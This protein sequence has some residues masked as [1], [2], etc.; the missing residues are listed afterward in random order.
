[1]TFTVEGRVEIRGQA[2]AA[3]QLRALSGE[4]QKLVDHTTGVSTRNK[5]AS[6][7]AAVFSAALTEQEEALRVLSDQL[8]PVTRKSEEFLAVQ[9]QLDQAVG[10]GL[11][12]RGDADKM[13]RAAEKS[14]GGIATAADDMGVRVGNSSHQFKNIAYQLNQI[15]QMGAVTK[16]W[17]GA[18]AIQI[19]DI[20]ASFGGLGM[21]LAGGA[22]AVGMSLVPAMLNAGAAAGDLTDMIDALQTSVSELN[23]AIDSAHGSLSEMTDRFGDNV[24]QARE[25]LAIQRQLAEL[26]AFA[27]FDDAMVGIDREF[28]VARRGAEEA[29]TALQEYRRLQA[30][31]SAALDE[32][33]R[34]G[35]EGIMNDARMT[36]ANNRLMTIR[37]QIDA[38]GDVEAQL[39]E[40]GS[41]FGVSA[42]Q[43]EQLVRA[44]E[45][46]GDAQGIADQTVA[47]Q[48]LLAM[49]RDFTKGGFGGTTEA[50]EM[51]RLL[52]DAVESGLELASLDLA[53]FDEDGAAQTAAQA[54]AVREMVDQYREQAQIAQAVNAFGQESLQVLLLRRE[55]HAA[56]VE[57]MIA[58]AGYAEEAA[59]AIREAAMAAYDAEEGILAGEVAAAA[60]GRTLGLLSFDA[61]I[62][63]ADTLQSKLSGMMGQA[64]SLLS[65]MGRAGQAQITADQQRDLLKTERDM[66]AAG[67]SRVEIEGALAEQRTRF[68]H[69]Q[70][71]GVKLFGIGDAVLDV[72]AGQARRT[73][74]ETATLN[75][76][77][78][79]LNR[80]QTEAAGSG[81]R[82]ADVTQK[83]RDAVADLIEALRAEIDLLG[84]SDPVQ[85]E[86]IK[87]RETL[88][89]ATDAERQEVQKLIEQRRDEEA[90]MSRLEYVSN[91]TGNALIQALM[92]AEDAGDRLIDTLLEA[93]L[94]AAILGDGPL[95]GLFG[96]G[97]FQTIGSAIGLPF[98]SGG[99]VFGEG[100]PTDDLV[101]AR[102]SPGEYV[103]NAKATRQH[104][105]LLDAINYGG[106]FASGGMVGGGRSMGAPQMAGGITINVDARGSQGEQALAEAA[107]NGVNEALDHYRRTGLPQDILR[108]LDD[109]QVMRF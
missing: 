58:E 82:Q 108:T 67:R 55:A 65:M 42:E 104:R 105:G 11:I 68:T 52:S 28:G 30:E 5:S 24:E 10:A 9:L 69:A 49:L 22:I 17:M 101:P 72:V 96:D 51:V 31:Y 45:A 20:M 44:T 94:Q 78:A 36:A 77:I 61:A 46:I 57:A 27:A 15:G 88:A 3:A 84:E 14:F 103:I 97:L 90:A 34:I 74:E 79:Q 76:E 83:S 38:L 98:A 81:N 70:I 109:Q 56:Q 66:L 19:P 1:M 60:L 87:H 39:R 73:A 62:A 80:A 99:L 16:D 63:G 106:A 26:D 25:V 75:E 13:L 6:D 95:G 102:L 93:T 2:Q 8:T 89:V 12:S 23:S 18:I 91:R 92:G 107:R 53:L 29:S 85:Q 40:L 4:T 59:A 32:A 54:R 35:S 86:M 21:V 50:R 64:S 48:Q 43:A 100:G 47:A 71:E 41:T 33:T 37:M 7:S